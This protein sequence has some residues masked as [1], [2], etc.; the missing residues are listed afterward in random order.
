ME[1]E[2]KREKNEQE[3]WKKQYELALQKFYKQIKKCKLIKIDKKKRFNKRWIVIMKKLLRYTLMYRKY[4][5][6]GLG[7][8]CKFYDYLV[9]SLGQAKI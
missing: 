3:A 6:F 9:S 8:C 2:E 4:K 1:L 7:N 5:N